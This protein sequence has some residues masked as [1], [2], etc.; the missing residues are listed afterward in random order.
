MKKTEIPRMVVFLTFGLP[1]L[2]PMLAFASVVAPG[3]RL[4]VVFDGGVFLE[5]PA[6]APDGSIYFS[7]VTRAGEHGLEAGHIWRYDPRTGKTA[8]FR[9]PS[10]KA[11]GLTFDAEG[12]LIAAEGADFGGRRITRTDLTTGKAIILAGLY[13]GRPF[14]A[15]NDLVIDVQGRIYFTDPRYLGHEPIEQP[16]MGVY[17]IDRDGSVHLVAADLSHPNGITISPDQKTLYVVTA[18]AT[19]TDITQKLDIARALQSGV[20]AYDL[21]AD[22]TVKFRQTLVEFKQE[23][24]GD[25]MTVDAEGNLYVAV[26]GPAAERGVHVFK[27]SGERIERIGTPAGAYNVEFGRGDEV[28]MLYIAAVRQLH[29]IK[30]KTSRFRLPWE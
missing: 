1:L 8:V 30:L 2:W 17:R 20:H 26:E 25:G 15:P 7:D 21:R 12:R 24:W 11:N 14:N 9:S 19:S 22:G 5:G 3:A 16:V 18:G 10:G 13:G 29:R 23:T 4:Q 6:A 27:P 28:N